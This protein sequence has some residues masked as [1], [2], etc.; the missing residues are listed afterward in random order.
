M[1][2]VN[3]GAENRADV[4]FCR[5]CGQPLVSA[6]A[7][8]SAVSGMICPSCGATVK[9]GGHF[10]PRCGGVLGDAR[11][12]AG[13]PAES[14]APR[15]LPPPSESPMLPQDFGLEPPR[16]RLANMPRSLWIVLA[17]LLLVACVIL[18]IATLVAWL[19]QGGRVLPF[20]GAASPTTTLTPMAVF[21]TPTS[22]VTPLPPT[23]TLTST[24]ALTETQPLT[25]TV[26]IVDAEVVLDVSTK[27][28]RIGEPIVFTITLTNTGEI[29]LARLRY[30]LDG[31][32][33]KTLAA[34]EFVGPM[35]EEPATLLPG[36]RQVVVLSLAGRRSGAAL[37]W[38][39]VTFE[40]Q[41]DPPR[42]DRRISEK[43]V[44]GVAP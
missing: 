6:P 41:L 10:C 27:L 36:E 29:P 2:C 5:K 23:P 33:D 31:E 3:C 11:L 1:Q 28:L 15:D 19:R 40:A 13:A 14:A 20:G 26:G 37:V 39:G 24:V 4:R 42:L 35:V 32:W 9:I 34:G 12:G 43:I 38:A 18:S 25:A 30:T 16:S 17:G 8:G 44:I 22:T 7:A 21:H